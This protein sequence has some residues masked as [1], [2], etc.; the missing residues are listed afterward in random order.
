V[1][2]VLLV[3]CHTS[4]TVRRNLDWRDEESIFLSGLTVNA[5]AGRTPFYTQVVYILVQNFPSSPS[6]QNETSLS[7]GIP[8]L[9]LHFL[10]F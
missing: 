7:A 9:C 1:L 8:C 4:K 6:P 2:S 5:K 3:V 10:S